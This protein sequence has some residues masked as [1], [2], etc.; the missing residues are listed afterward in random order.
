[1]FRWF[2]NEAPL[3]EEQGRVRVKHF[4]KGST[5]F[6]ILKFR[7]LETLDTG[8]FRCEADNGD[9]TVKST[10]VIKVMFNTQRSPIRYLVFNGPK[11]RMNGK[12]LENNSNQ[13]L[14][15]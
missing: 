13:R 7:E 6:S 11:S 5:Q 14:T 8:Y 4:L 12:I 9:M 3:I 2:K 1:M 10:A 15:Y